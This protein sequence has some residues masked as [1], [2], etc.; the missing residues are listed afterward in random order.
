MATATKRTALRKAREEQG[1]T[2]QD[3]ADYCDVT[4]RYIQ[5]IELGERDPSLKVARKIATLLGEPVMTLFPAPA[6]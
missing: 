6:A 3:V 4:S 1:Y 2:Q 5:A